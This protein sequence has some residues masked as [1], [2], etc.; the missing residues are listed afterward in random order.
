LCSDDDIIDCKNDN[1]TISLFLFEKRNGNEITSTS[2]KEWSEADKSGN[3]NNSQA[4]NIVPGVIGP[5]G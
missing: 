3:T 5:D 1:E 4:N 2:L